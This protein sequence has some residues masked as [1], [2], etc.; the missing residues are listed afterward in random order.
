MKKQTL[1]ALVD[2]FEKELQILIQSAKSAHEASTHEESRAEDRHDTFAIEASYLAAGQ[3]ERVKSIRKTLLELNHF[4][5][6]ST[7]AFS[8]ALPGAL[9]LLE[10]DGKQTYS[11]LCISGGGAQVKI[12]GKMVTLI[13][14]LSPLGEQLQGL[15]AGD[16]FTLENKL[17]SKDYQVLSVY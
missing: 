15:S 2:Y 16:V 12:E 3:S 5:E 17:E 13:S 4:L 9:V 11:F 14:T 1:L 10:C 6:S 8:R 7:Q